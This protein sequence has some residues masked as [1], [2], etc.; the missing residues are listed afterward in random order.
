M[1]Y[2]P[3]IKEFE[4]EVL[5]ACIAQLKAMGHESK[6]MAA[7]ARRVTM[8][9]VAAVN[10][11]KKPEALLSCSYDSMVNC[12]MMTAV[13]GLRP[14]GASQLV[15]L[16]PQSG[17]MQWRISHR[18]LAA[19]AWDAGFHLMGVPVHK[20]DEYR[21]VTGEILEHRRTG[22]DIKT[23]D[24]IAGVYVVIKKV[25]ETGVFVIA[26]PFMTIYEIKRAK[27]VSR[28][29]NVW[30]DWPAAMASKTAIKWAVARA[31]VPIRSD[32]MSAAITED[33]RNEG[34][35]DREGAP[36]TTP[37]PEPRQIEAPPE[38]LTPDF[39]AEN[40]RLNSREKVSRDE[41]DDEIRHTEKS[42]A[43]GMGTAEPF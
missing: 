26:T 42:N 13:T 22:H 33:N 1:A 9:F 38:D 21:E 5:K 40:D 16:V 24:D 20:D 28:Y 43:R 34:Y 18:G 37:T 36:K 27:A 32:E 31:T 35:L 14:G 25:T 17:E 41:A 10:A 11:A 30:R 12:V 29:G 8:T 15:Y 3:T 19:L 39:T 7:A 2:I 23:L 4:A 6:T